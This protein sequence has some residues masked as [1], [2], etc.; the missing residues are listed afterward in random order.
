MKPVDFRTIITQKTI[1]VNRKEE[2][3]NRV[4]WTKFN[5]AVLRQKGNTD[6]AGKS[7]RM[8]AKDDF[9]DYAGGLSAII[10]GTYRN[11]KV[12]RCLD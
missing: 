9:Q 5:N 7:G 4:T 2:F 12:F 1:F 11:C 6:G 3:A 10:E 8:L